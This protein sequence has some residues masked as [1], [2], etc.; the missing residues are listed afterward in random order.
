M[1]DLLDYMDRTSSKG[2]EM[3]DDNLH[4]YEMDPRE[5]ME[6]GLEERYLELSPL[7]WEVFRVRT[8]NEDYQK[9]REGGD[10]GPLPGKQHRGPRRE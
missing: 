2:G 6:E 3:Y 7:Q 4:E 5:L 8:E 9:P 10:R 1:G